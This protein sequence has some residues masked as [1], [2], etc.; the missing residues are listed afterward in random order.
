MKSLR[1][2]KPAK[3]LPILEL[4][5]TGWLPSPLK[6]ALYRLR[7][8]TVHASAK[9]GFGCVIRG[10]HVVIGPEVSIGMLATI[11]GKKIELGPRVRIGRLSY[12]NTAVIS[13]GENTRIGSQ[14]V[15]GGMQSV[16]SEFRM[17]S[18]GILME[19]SFVNTTKPVII[20][21]DVGIGGHCLL[22][23]HGL[24]PNT[25]DGFPSQFAG[26]TIEDEVWIAWRVSILPGVTIGA[27]SII[28][29]DA[30]VVKDIPALCLAAGTPAKIL[31]EHGSY[32]RPS[33]N[34]ARLEQLIQ[35]YAQWCCYQ[36]AIIEEQSSSHLRLKSA[37]QQGCVHLH[38]RMQEP[39][40]SDITTDG[41]DVHIL[42]SLQPINAADRQ[43]LTQRH[44]HW[45]DI[46]SRHRS[47][48]PSPALD[49]IEEFM[50]RAGLR[51]LKYHS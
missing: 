9:L 18:N 4:L 46:A 13:I 34:T 25:F 1:L 24:W 21:N 37:T 3:A 38:V 45:M 48:Q 29:T 49:D 42:I 31:R 51:L 16:D 50:R 15:V 17:G 12:L 14:V 8:Y 6:R 32:I 27:R 41:T 11:M 23:T 20:G 22:F 26:I 5:L 47:Q 10:E 40:I 43:L 7:G 33:D 2:Y 39:N 36:G 44:I 19:W 30:C 28:S 35:E